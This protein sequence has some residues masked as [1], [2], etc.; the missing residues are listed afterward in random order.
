[1]LKNFG[2]RFKN[3]KKK[4]KK[5]NQN[6]SKKVSLKTVIVEVGICLQHIFKNDVAFKITFGFVMDSY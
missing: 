6:P 3:Q 2:S 4:K 5:K 1:M